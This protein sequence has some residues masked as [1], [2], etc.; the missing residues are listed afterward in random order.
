MNRAI[1]FVGP[2]RIEG[3]AFPFTTDLDDERFTADTDLCVE[4]FGKGGRP[5]L[6]DHGLDDAMKTV[7]MGRQDDFELRDE[8]IW[9]QSTLDKHAQY[10]KAVDKLIEQGAL[11]YSSGAMA[12]LAT[13]S[14]NGDI[15][16]WPWVELSM[17]PTPANPDTLGVHYVKSAVAFEHMAAADI[18]IPDPL[19]AAL[20]AL[21][22]WADNRETPPG[23]ETFTARL[24]R[25]SS[26]VA[27]LTTHAREHLEM[28][29]KSGRVLSAANRER[30]AA[31]IA[32]WEPTL[33]DLKQFLAETDPEAGKSL[34]DAVWEAL[35]T[36]AHLNGVPV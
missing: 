25:V 4:W 21:D 35:R 13:K 33:A 24:D 17:T 36:Q 20:K 34:N 27:G 10:R 9:A 12:H 23:S 15:T 32:A 1:K 14:A 7:V 19:K 11:G 18:V 8:G 29:V 2:D 22:E 3:L 16:R 6:Y 31:L 30:L 5:L 28:R 26:E